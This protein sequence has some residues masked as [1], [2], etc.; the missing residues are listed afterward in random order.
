MATKVVQAATIKA[1]L[2]PLAH[3]VDASRVRWTTSLGDQAGLTKTGIHRASLP[4]GQTGTVEH[5]H[6]GDDEWCY[7]L[8]GSGLLLQGTEGTDTELSA[9]DFVG[10]PAGS[11]TPHAFRAGD[12][13]LEYLVGGSRE[14]QDICH[15]PSLNKAM[16]VDRVTGV[17][18]VVDEEE[19]HK[20]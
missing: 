18:T 9:G 2:K 19:L 15:Y 4:P 8:S 16:L 13:G 6:E 14:P 10:F 17:R 7:I 5:W 12:D 3:P 11:K 20:S 1:A